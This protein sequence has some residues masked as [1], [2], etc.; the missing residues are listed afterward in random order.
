MGARI[1]VFL[2]REQDKT[3]LNLRIFAIAV[4]TAVKLTVIINPLSI[5]QIAAKFYV[6]I[7]LVKLLMR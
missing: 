6:S 7:L 4:A 5:S 2:T 1:R 3:L